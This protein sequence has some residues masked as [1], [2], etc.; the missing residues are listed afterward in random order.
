SLGR[1]IPILAFVIVA[2]AAIW[3]NFRHRK[4]THVPEESLELERT[5]LMLVIIVTGVI[6]FASSIAFEY[7]IPLPWAVLLAIVMI[8]AGWLRRRKRK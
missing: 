6:G 7:G 1:E 2:T 5:C 8:A 4:G 3:L